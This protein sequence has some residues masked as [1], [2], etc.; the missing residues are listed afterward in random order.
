MWPPYQPPQYVYPQSQPMGQIVV[1]REVRVTYADTTPD[2]IWGP[3]TQPAAEQL[4][5]EFAK[6]P[7]VIRK[8]KIQ[9][10]GTGVS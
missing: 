8:I 1:D 7:Q 2:T 9:Q 4:A 5:I 3:F 6:S 10:S